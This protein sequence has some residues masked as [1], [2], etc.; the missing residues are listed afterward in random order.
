MSLRQRALE[1]YQ[2]YQEEQEKRRLAE[3]RKRAKRLAEI[4]AEELD[5]AGVSPEVNPDVDLSRPDPIDAVMVAR[6]RLLF[7][8]GSNEELV[9]VGKCTNCEEYFPIMELGVEMPALAELGKYLV[10]EDGAV[11]S[12]NSTLCPKCRPRQT[13]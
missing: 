1:A 4:M 13:S 3:R 11:L 2:K 9:L 5:V 12:P 6:E 8:L 7:A 10:D